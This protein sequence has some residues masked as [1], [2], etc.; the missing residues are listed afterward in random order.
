MSKRILIVGAGANQVPIIARARAMGLFAIAM[1]GNPEAPGF[2]EAD[3]YEAA[4]ITD[5][6][7]IVRVAQR[8][9]ANAVYVAAEWAVEATARATTA[10]GLP[11]IRPEVAERV[12]NKHA[13]R[14]ALQVAGIPGPAF[15]LATTE[16][17]ALHAFVSIGG[18]VIVKPSDGNA[19]RG[20]K[21]VEHLDEMPAAFHLAQGAARNGAALIEQY[22]DGEEFN[23]DGLV[24]NGIYRL[25]GITGKE[26]SAPP[27]RF[28]LAINMPPLEDSGLQAKIA[29]HVATALKAIGF[30]I[31]TT[32]A[33]V[34]VTEQ[35]PRIVEIAGRPGGGRI[36][37][38]LIPLT[39]GIDY[40]ADA[41]RIAL[42][43]AP[44]EC[45]A[46]ERGTAVYWIPAEPGVV[47]RISGVDEVRAMVGIHDV[48]VTA[49]VGDTL[50]PIVDCATRD[51]VGYVIAQADSAREAMSLAK[52]AASCIKIETNA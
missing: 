41:L 7:E 52:R 5:A 30:T 35:G 40:T 49:R 29:E 37:T 18:P 38:D 2:P 31:G 21:R 17:E 19:S 24:H 14:K 28:D 1:D 36:P 6:A 8:F 43:E 20:V 27:N 47:T 45:R 50:A 12:R 33:E 44:S 16:Q 25:G 26:R 51:K 15:R 3:V 4:N 10:L 32:H 42:G 39:Y 48:V 22:L 11:G 13:M 34:I 9:Q 46:F 23:V